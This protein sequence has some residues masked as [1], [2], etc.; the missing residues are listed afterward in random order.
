[1]L[2][3]NLLEQK[4][5]GI[6]TVDPAVIFYNDFA[7]FPDF[8]PLQFELIGFTLRII[9]A[10]FFLFFSCK[11]FNMGSLLCVKVL[12]RNRG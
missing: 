1:M 11:H 6:G 5:S 9:K 12:V 8:Q 7:G 3:L 10:G 2:L 4:N